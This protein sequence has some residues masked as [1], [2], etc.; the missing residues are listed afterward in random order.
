MFDDC[1]VTKFAV[2]YVFSLFVL[3]A[4]R[5]KNWTQEQLAE[6][7]CTSRRWIQLIETGRRMPG[8]CLAVN[9]MLVLGIDP[10]VLLREIIT[11]TRKGGGHDV[12]LSGR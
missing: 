12:P 10:S 2:R 3:N 5:E 7:V 11:Q 1:I 8:F 6:Q 9:L 4:R